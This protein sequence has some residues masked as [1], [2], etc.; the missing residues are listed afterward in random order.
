LKDEASLEWYPF[1]PQNVDLLG[2]KNKKI[3]RSIALVDIED[4]TI[5]VILWLC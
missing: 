1:G 4:V 5:E 2:M 3:D